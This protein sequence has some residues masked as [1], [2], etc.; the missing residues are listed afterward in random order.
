MDRVPKP[1]M[2]I[3]RASMD[4]DW[5]GLVKTRPVSAWRETLALLATYSSADEWAGLCDQLAR[6]LA[7]S[8]QAHAASLCYVC[9]GNVD[10]AVSHW[11]GALAAAS[12][13]DAAVAAM[14]G[15][16]E[17]SVVFGLASG[18]KRGGSGSLAELVTAYAGL[19]ASQVWGVGMSIAGWLCG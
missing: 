13:G 10:A 11:G 1:F 19:L 7:A 9:A 5:A 16:I 14:Q 17:K 3:L 6:R 18:G 8:G 2:Q 12:G 4:S 15:V